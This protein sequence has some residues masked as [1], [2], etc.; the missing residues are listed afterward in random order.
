MAS[1][2]VQYRTTARTTLGGTYSYNYFGYQNN[3]GSD[4]ASSVGATLSHQFRSHWTVNLYGGVTRNSASGV[5]VVP[6]NLLIG[7]QAVGGYEIGNYRRYPISRPSPAPSLIATA[8][9]RCKRAEA[10]VLPAATAIF[11]LPKT[12]ISVV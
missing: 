1:A 9:F 5:I 10:K 8:I 2:S 7:N 12:C 4:S 11:S 6:V 3:A